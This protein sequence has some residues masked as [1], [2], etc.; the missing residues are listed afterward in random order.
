MGGW[1]EKLRG[2]FGPRPPRIKVRVLIKGRIGEGWYDI[3]RQL[4]VPEGTNLGQLIDLAES[5]GVPFRDAIEHSP[6]LR[7]TLMWNGDRCPVDAFIDRPLC[8]GDQLYLLAPLAG[9]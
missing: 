3:D 5:R 6:H 4:K 2:V 8:D 7:H 1:S 9:G